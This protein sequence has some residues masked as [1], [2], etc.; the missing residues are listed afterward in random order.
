M[1]GFVPLGIASNL[2]KEFMRIFSLAALGAATFG[3][4]T[5]AHA[6]EPTAAELQQQLT[7]LQ[8]RLN[9]VEAREATQAE[10]ARTSNAVSADASSRS[11]FLQAE[12]VVAGY[13][14]GFFIQ[15]A[16]GAFSFKPGLQ[17]QFRSVT[18]YRQ[19]APDDD[20][21][22][23]NGFEIRRARFRFDGNAFSKD[24][25]YSFVFD[26]S[27]TS[28]SP[29]LLDGYIGYRFATEWAFKAG[30]FKESWTHEKDI[31]A[32]NQLAV[33]RSLV[34]TLLG[35]NLT[36]R[37]QGVALV[38]GSKTNPLRAELTFSDGA[39]SK[40]TDFTDTNGANFGVGGRVEYRFSGDWDAYKDFTAKGD[41]EDLLVAGAGFDY[42]E[43]GDEDVARV[44]VDAQ[45]ELT[46]GWAFYAGVIGNFDF[47]DDDTQSYGGV[48]QVAYLI[49]D[50]W[51]A[52]GRYDIVYL[53][54]DVAD[55][56]TYS[57]LA[58]GA[59]YYLGAGG[60]AV[61]RAKVTVDLLYLPDGSPGNQTG[62]G[63]LDSG[64]SQ[65]AVRG[66]FTLQL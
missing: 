28:G 39:N 58:V 4:V 25:T 66:Q 33:D 55:D 20:K 13:N 43:Y 36:D 27:R 19:N 52:F 9:A 46:S 47:G 65:F 29:A 54:D 2:G 48:A 42:T 51:E 40:N 45:Y 5:H 62:I 21:D 50:H 24:L 44:T 35:G 23:Q 18:N 56:N 61:N 60:S 16:D 63:V 37:V 11:Q 57:E 41:K 31:S 64:D 26:T 15:S 34:D 6:A 49:D 32:F 10:V 30:Q 8:N 7:T 59:N 53:D 3:V 1:D 38:Y 14:K 12:G 22:T 17:F